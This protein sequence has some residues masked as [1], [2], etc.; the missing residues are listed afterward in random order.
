M[1]AIEIKH[2]S[3]AYPDGHPA[4]IDINLLVN[5]GECLG[6]IGPNGAGK[7]TLLLHLN[8]LLWAHSGEIRVLGQPII[9]S[10]LS[11]I[12]KTVGLVFQNPDDQLF[13]PTLLE[14]VAFGPLNSGIPGEEISG[15][16]SRALGKVGLAGFEN[17]SPHH[18]SVGEKRKASLA[19]ILSMDPE[20]IVLDEPS[21]NLDPRSRKELIELL[22]SF[23]QTRIVATH[24]LEM[25][26]QLCDRVALLAR[27]KVMTLGSPEDL[28]TDEPLLKA[29]GLELPEIL[30][31]MKVSDRKAFVL[32]QRQSRSHNI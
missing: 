30:R 12:R 9:K 15:R 8:G 31:P 17:R 20:I 5:T 2:L 14:D 7:S 27:G 16:V 22:A 1:N 26:L 21:S 29:H 3:Y 32:D 28:L 13:C 24:D 25:V 18:M 4:L 11:W 23:P 19:T 6:L 10:N